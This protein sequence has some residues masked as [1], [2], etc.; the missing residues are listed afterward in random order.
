M[1]IVIDNVLDEAHRQ[2]VA[3]FFSQS[4]E[5]RIMRWEAGGVDSLNGNQSPMAL[6]LKAAAAHF[7]LTSMVGSEY[8]AHYGTRPD[9]HVDKDERL[10]DNSGVIECPLCSIVY[11]ADIDVVGGNFVTETLSIKP[12]TNRLIAFHP[13]LLHSVEPFTG[14]RLAVAVN[15]W[16]KKPT[17]YL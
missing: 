9:W 13:G 2:A 5:S 4:D 15:P 6:L 10:Y 1:L 17:A 8:W 7:D 11:Y 12:I 3:G 14:T 16:N